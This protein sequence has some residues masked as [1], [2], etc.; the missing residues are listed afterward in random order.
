MTDPTQ[1][2]VVTTTIDVKLDNRTVT[3][4]KLPIKR[5]TEVFDILDKIPKSIEQMDQLSY[6]KILQTVPSLVKTALPEV[7]AV[8]VIGS[9]LKKEEVDELALDEIMK[10]LA[11]II[12]VN[13]YADVMNEI[14]KV[15]ARPQ[16]ST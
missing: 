16:A 6:D 11:G 8:I 12:E 1:T 5:Y 9:G 2:Q 4:S 15:F 14:K 10:L 3:L 13:K 7:L